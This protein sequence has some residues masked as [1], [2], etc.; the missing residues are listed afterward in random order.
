MMNLL[1]KLST[2]DYIRLKDETGLKHDYHDGRR[3]YGRRGYGWLVAMSGVTE[4]HD[5]VAS[6][7]RNLLWDCLKKKGCRI[8]SSD[9]RVFVP[10][11]NKFVYPD[12]TVVCGESQRHKLP[13]GAYVLTNP[14][15]IVEV[16]SEG[17]V[18]YDQEEKYHCYQSLE[19]FRA[20]LL[21]APDQ[22]R[23]E[24]RKK[25]TEGS[26]QTEVFDQKDQ[27]VVVLGYAIAVDQIYEDVMQ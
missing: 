23:V 16:S 7:I 27:T 2:E 4:E 18:E 19:S 13:R 10:V 8:Y 6:A 12:A 15:A 20:Y 24:I 17:T 14:S 25:S 22:V 21:V 11:C 9:I 3:G 1:E 26:W 5:L